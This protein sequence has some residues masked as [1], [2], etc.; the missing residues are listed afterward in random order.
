MGEVRVATA[1]VLVAASDHVIADGAVAFG[2]R[3]VLAVGSRTE[4]LRQHPHA[5]RWAFADRAII[6][7][8][9]NAHTHLC[10]TNLEGTVPYTGDFAAWLQTVLATTTDW[11]IQQHLHSLRDGIAAALHAGTAAVGD[12]LNEWPLLTAYH[13]H[14]LGGVVF[15]QVTG[16]NPVIA[17][18]WLAHLEQVFNGHVGQ[19]L[20]HL[21]LGISPHAPYSTSA[22]LYRDSFRFALERNA[23]LMTHLAETP[24]E[25]D[26]LHTG[27]GIYR[28]LLEERGT[29]VSGW[30]PPRTSPVQY[31]W[32]EGVLNDRFL[33]AH[34]NYPSESDIELMAR[35]EGHVVYC[36]RSHA[37]FGHPRHPLDRLLGAGINVALGT[38]SLASNESLSVLGEMK[39]VR[40]RYP[41]LP[42]EAIFRLGT[43]NGARMLR[44]DG[45]Y[46]TLLPSR[47][48]SFNVVRTADRPDPDRVLEQILD[49]AAEIE[50]IVS[51]GERA[52]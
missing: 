25:E 30:T 7:G 31:L 5:E 50:T 36:P 21:G 48:A 39:L 6:P 33:Y 49:P 18:V 40:Q 4:I 15:L 47:R 26:F 12:I 11:K 27:A 3:E 51:W 24:E 32:Q 10:L 13:G 20:P 8:L 23:L 46:G 44:V 38:D 41:E 29:W 9:V 43:I 42:P 22:K 2:D 14:P 28:R 19:R 37:F 35:V 16:F 34:V 45:K 52:S 1:D 17:P